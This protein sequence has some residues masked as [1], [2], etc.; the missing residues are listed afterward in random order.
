MESGCRSG[1]D[2]LFLN[3]N[4]LTKWITRSIPFLKCELLCPEWETFHWDNFFKLRTFLVLRLPNWSWLIGIVSCLSKSSNFGWFAWGLIWTFLCLFLWLNW[5][6][7]TVWAGTLIALVLEAL[8]RFWNAFFFLIQ[9]VWWCFNMWE[10]IS[11]R[12]WKPFPYPTPSTVF[13]FWLISNWR[14]WLVTFQPLTMS[15]KGNGII[16]AF[17]SLATCLFSKHKSQTNK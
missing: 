10:I 15:V 2:N 14:C 7:E 11:E 16:D 9:V 1:F 8:P 6:G 12:S 5:L 13:C 3:F 17:L 4:G